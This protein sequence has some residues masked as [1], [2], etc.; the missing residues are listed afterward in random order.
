MKSELSIDII[1][2]LDEFFILRVNRVLSWLNQSDRYLDI[3]HIKN[4]CF[5]ATSDRTQIPKV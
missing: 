3:H 4:L 1:F 2:P 5:A